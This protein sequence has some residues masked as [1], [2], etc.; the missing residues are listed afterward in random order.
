MITRAPY[1]S[2]FL[3][4]ANTNLNRLFFAINLL[5]IGRSS[6]YLL[7]QLGSISGLTIVDEAHRTMLSAPLTVLCG[8]T[9]IVWLVMVI[10]RFRHT[11]DRERKRAF[12]KN[13]SQ[14]PANTTT[15]PTFIHDVWANSR[16]TTRTERQPNSDINSVLAAPYESSNTL[17]QNSILALTATNQAAANTFALDH[18]TK[19]VSWSDTLLVQLEWRRFEQVCIYFLS[20]LVLRQSV[21]FKDPR[22]QSRCTSDKPM[23]PKRPAG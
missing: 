7:L 20:R 1:L 17:Q 5:L 2:P 14:E 18:A 15:R 4:R 21:R 10:Q 23:G 6:A 13:L 11:R 19:P 22:R 9:I 3:M 16:M 12:K 8:L